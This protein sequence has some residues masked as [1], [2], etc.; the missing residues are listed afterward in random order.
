[1]K[2]EKYKNRYILAEGY[3][4]AIGVSNYYE[5]RIHKEQVG[6][7]MIALEWPEELWDKKLPKYRLV[8]ERVK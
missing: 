2:R 5:I 7:D 4:Y 3:P 8:L 1:M 6:C